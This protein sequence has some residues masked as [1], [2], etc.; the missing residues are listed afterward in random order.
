[1]D[2]K[3]KC[4]YRL[5]WSLIAFWGSY[6]SQISLSS[7]LRAWPGPHILETIADRVRRDLL[8]SAAHLH[9]RVNASQSP[10]ERA[11]KVPLVTPGF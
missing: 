10:Y 6:D 1:M 4:G 5:S 8:S 3:L 7:F 9:R 11:E 2:F